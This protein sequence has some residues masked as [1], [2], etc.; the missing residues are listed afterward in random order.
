MN[1]EFYKTLSEGERR[2]V[3]WQY[4]RSGHFVT[5]LFDAMAKADSQNLALLSKA[6]PDEV[7][8]Y[9][10]FTR[11]EGY[12]PKIRNGL[13]PPE[14]DTVPIGRTLVVITYNEDEYRVPAPD[15]TEAGSYYTDDK[16]DAID[17]CRNFLYKGTD[18]QIRFMHK[19]V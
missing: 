12:W 8:A 4:G 7:K 1:Y 6:Y 11:E 18:V 13:Y 16:D 10:R 15:G 19:E 2:L 5:L 3:D 14:S 17:T 9:E